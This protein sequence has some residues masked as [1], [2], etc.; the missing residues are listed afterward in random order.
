[1]KYVYRQ[2][3][4][5]LATLMVGFSAGSRVEFGSKYPKGMA[6][7]MEHLRF[8]GTALKDHKVLAR[9]LAA[10]GGNWNAFTSHDLVC[11]HISIPEENLDAGCRIMGDLIMRPI[12]P[13]EELDKE[14]EVICQEIRM[15]DD[16][17][18]SLVSKHVYKSVFE[19]ALHTTVIGFEDTVRQITRQDLMNFNEEFYGPQQMAVVLASSGDHEDLITKHLVSNDGVLK[20]IP[21]SQDVKYANSFEG[22]VIKAGLIQNMISINFGSP[23]IFK[24]SNPKNEARVEMF[25]R[26]FGG[27][28]VSRLFIKVREDL[29]LVYGIRSG[30]SETLDGA[31]FS[32][33]TLTEPDNCDKVI[34]AIDSEVTRMLKEPPTAEEMSMA[35]NKFKSMVYAMMDSSSS[36]ANQAL[37]ETFF[38]TQPIQK[39]LSEIEQ[40]TSEDVME[41]AKTIFGGNKYTVIGKG[42][43]Q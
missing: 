26:I 13:A 38:D 29:G 15:Y 16:E 22:E 20:R 37:Y 33:S 34:E 4:S 11:Y 35:K 9:E 28:D 3:S 1:M 19:N 6:H 18:D 30:F 40:L 17:I 7:L 23:E 24:L 2:H 39:T 5:K 25:N 41:V 36:A 12:F 32:T 43:K 42:K 31:L 21:K 14:K 8:K 10:V 27:G